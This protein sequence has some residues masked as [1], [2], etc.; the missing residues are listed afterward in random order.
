MV[1]TPG[2]R[3]T[4]ARA[5]ALGT[6]CV[7]GVL[8]CARGI[9]EG[10]YRWPDAAVHAMDGAVF[11]DWV[12]TGPA[13]WLDPIGFATQQYACY[14]ALGIGVQYPP[15]FAVAEAG[16]FAVLG[17]SP[18]SGRVTVV[19]FALLAFIATY[20]LIERVYGAA[21]ALLGTVLLLQMPVIVHW[22]RQIMLELPALAA[23]SWSAFLFLRYLDRP[24]RGR[25]IAFVAVAALTPFFKQTAAFLL[26][27]FLVWA[28]VRRRSVGIPWRHV[29]A[30]TAVIVVVVGGY[31]ALIVHQGPVGVRL[32]SQG[33]S[34]WSCLGWRSWQYVFVGLVGAAGWVPSVLAGAGLL[35]GIRRPSRTFVMACA[36]LASFVLLSVWVQ[37]KDARYLLWGLWP[38]AV[39]AGVFSAEVIRLVPRAELRSAVVAG[40]TLA[41]ALAGFYQP[42]PPGGRDYKPLIV[43]HND[44]IRGQIVLFAGDREP[45]FVLAAR[46]VLGPR[47]AVVL[48]SSKLLYYCAGDLRN[49]YHER[50][51]SIADVEDVI[52]AY[53]P[54]ALFIE[55]ANTLGIRPEALL[56]QYVKQTGAYTYA[57]YVPTDPKTYSEDFRAVDVYLRIAP[58]NRTANAIELPAP[59]GGAHVRVALKSLGF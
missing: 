20:L 14:P 41:A 17:V 58:A 49:D 11:H 53:A 30:A 4:H 7:V 28:V 34:F 1:H 6:V 56:R 10:G 24:S 50:V 23:L 51:H 46:Q 8:V 35:L 52:E 44:A 15:A 55:R 57:G 3:T 2:F 40:G 19:A 32:L 22:S 25:L 39:F 21:G 31:F 9:T 48:R 37:E 13:A 42:V 33:K 16:V 29:V 26:P 54:R 47:G 12:A 38:F 59:T 27:V 18:V 45:G 43:A 5:L 36:W